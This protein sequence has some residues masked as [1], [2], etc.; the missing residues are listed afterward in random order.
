MRKLIRASEDAKALICAGYTSCRDAGGIGALGLRD[1]INEGT[2]HGPRILAAGRPINSTYGH[3]GRNPLPAKYY[4]P[5]TYADGVDECIKAVRTRLREGS[6]FIK[7]STG[8]WGESKTYL[9]GGCIPSYTVKEIKA[10][11][12]EAES[13]G[14]F[15]MTHANG[16]EGIMNALEAGVFSIEYGGNH[17]DQ[18]KDKKIFRTMIKNNAVWTPTT[19]I[20]WKPYEYAKKTFG[21][22]DKEIKSWNEN[23]FWGLRTANEMGVRIASGTDYSGSGSIGGQSMGTN[24]SFN[25]ELLVRAG[26]PPMDV[27]VAATRRGAE[28]MRKEKDLGTLEEGKLADMI[29]VDGDPISDIKIFQEIERIKLVIKDGKIVVNRM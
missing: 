4:A 27:I 20:V 21:W 24:N 3:I 6:D 19:A 22:N 13:L 18:K 10:M 12:H 5:D 28:A 25:L 15:V 29:V 7:I 9:E 11:N 1:A 14:F 2:I 17:H 8:L 23:L 26:I 16:Y